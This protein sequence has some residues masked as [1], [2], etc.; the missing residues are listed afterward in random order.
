MERNSAGSSVMGPEMSSI[1]TS[2][3]DK[4]P[5]SFDGHS[6]YELY[7]QDVELWLC[8]T[9]LDDTKQGPAIIRRLEGEPKYSARSP[10]TAVISAPDGA[11]KIHEH[12]D[13]SD[14]VD[15]TDQLDLGLASFLDYSWDSKTSIETSTAGFHARLGELAELNLNTKLQGHLLLRQAR[16]DSHSKN[17]IIE[18]RAISSALRQ[19][20]RN[21]VDANMLTS[22]QHKGEEDRRDFSD[23]TCHYC[24][25]KGHYKRDCRKL[26]AKN[27]DR[28]Q[29]AVPTKDTRNRTPQKPP[30]FCSFANTSADSTARALI[31]TGACGSIVG[32]DTLDSACGRWRF[33]LLK[34]V[35]LRGIHTG[36][37][38]S[39]PNTV[40]YFLIYY[41]FS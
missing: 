9:N 38:I 33:L 40:H 37:E 15:D 32:K 11:H 29:N 36:F 20:F 35:L 18:V 8:L 16:L 24:K 1:V 41:S 4:I 25:K 6:R 17:M 14:G 30:T 5:P 10:G 2:F 19:A 34:T 22:S 28:P 26:M 31:D 21:P 7:G 39:L 13:R 27:R 23:I 12:L 3:S